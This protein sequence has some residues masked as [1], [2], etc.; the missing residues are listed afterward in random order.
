M[1]ISRVL[2][3]SPVRPRDQQIPGDRHQPCARH[4]ERVE[5]DG[6][7]IRPGPDG[8][9]LG[10]VS[11]IRMR[12]LMREDACELLIVRLHKQSGRHV[13]FAATRIGGIDVGIIH[14]PDAD[15]I[16]RNQVIYLLQ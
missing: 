5:Q 1:A 2:R 16:Q 8:L 14:Q 11:E 7:N 13:K 12:D 6:G 15:M 3:V 9:Q 10:H 4:T